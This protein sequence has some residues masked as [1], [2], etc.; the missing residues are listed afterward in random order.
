MKRKIQIA[1]LLLAATLFTSNLQAAPQSAK[2]TKTTKPTAR[3]SAAQKRLNEQLSIA[4]IKNDLSKVKTLVSRGANVN[5]RSQDGI[6]VLHLATSGVGSV[7]ITKFLLDKGALVNRADNYGATSLIDVAKSGE[8]NTAEI[9]KLLLTRGANVN[10]KDK[11]GGTAI[12]YAAINGETTSVKLLAAA[13]ANVNAADEQ[14]MTPLMMTALFDEPEIAQQLIQ[15]GANLEA[16]NIIGET[17]LMRAIQSG[18]TR[19]VK[20]LLN[21]GA[22]PLTWSASGETPLSMAEARKQSDIIA[23]LKAALKKKGLS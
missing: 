17:A 23:L 1:S 14:G 21:K 10:A 7:A 2:A 19:L 3:V 18:N 8:K 4:I 5:A 16:G 15:L 6:P 22:N 13:K 9:T 11:V 12:Y 20:I